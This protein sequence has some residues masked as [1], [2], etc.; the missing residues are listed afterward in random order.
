[1]NLVKSLEFIFVAQRPHK[2]EAFSVWKKSPNGLANLV[3]IIIA[4]LVHPLGSSIKVN[5]IHQMVK[6]KTEEHHH[7]TKSLNQL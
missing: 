7:T 3:T 1:M 5:C 6:D 4:S 2:G